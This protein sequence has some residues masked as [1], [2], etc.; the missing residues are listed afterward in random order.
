MQEAPKRILA[1]IP[2][3]KLIA[4]L[5]EPVERAYSAYRHLV[6]DGRE[7]LP[8]F[9]DALAA[10][11]ARMA[12]NWHPHWHYLQRG[13][14]FA[15]LR[16]FYELFDRQQI[17]VYTYDEFK[18]NP[19][20]TIRSIFEFLGLD[21][22]FSPDTSIRHNVSGTPRS[23]LLH[24]ALVRPSAIR[25]GAKSF[26]PLKARRRLRA[27]LMARN[28]VAGEPR[29]APETQR[30]LRRLYRNDLLHLEKLLDRDLSGWQGDPKEGAPL[31]SP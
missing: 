1:D 30:A 2:D 14:Y 10:E 16:R 29:I 27:A 22:T 13:F 21:P 31:T 3:V 24:A 15:Q 4:V 25:D 5:R 18:S 9:E 26:L 19:A 23:R 12:A 7:P 8:S 17:A 20:E 6:R 11:P 28:I